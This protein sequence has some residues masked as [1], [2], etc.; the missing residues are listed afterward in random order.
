MII[1]YDNYII[2]LIKIQD[3]INMINEEIII[4]MI[5]FDEGDPKRIQHFLKVYEFAHLIGLKENLNSETLKILD[6]TSIMH[7]I[8]IIPSEKKYGYQN[9]KLQEIEGPIYARELLKEFKEVKEEEIERICFLIG[10]HHTYSDVDNI[11]YQILLEADFLVNAYEDNLNKDNI[12]EFK[13]KVFKTKTGTN[14]LDT[15]FKLKD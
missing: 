2:N 6:I 11:D 14:L 3:N 10:H 15:M 13:N 4:R 8:G 12:I 1:I 7:D 9:G 5:K